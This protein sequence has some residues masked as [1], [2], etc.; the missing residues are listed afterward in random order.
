VSYNGW[1]N[2]ETWAVALWIDNDE[3]SQGYVRDMATECV[4]AAPE[5][6]NARSGLWT[7]EQA[8]RFL[9]SDQLKEWVE[10]DLLPDLGATLAADLLGAAVSEVSWDELA[11]HYLESE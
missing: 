6:E 11:K 2:Y 8:A 10:S 9:L 3:G 7:R 4:D 1:T 5:S